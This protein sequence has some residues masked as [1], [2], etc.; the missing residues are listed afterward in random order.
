[1]ENFTNFVS[2]LCSNQ[3]KFI[4]KVNN[5]VEVKDHLIPL[6][7]EPK[8]RIVERLCRLYKLDEK[9]LDILDNNR[10]YNLY[11]SILS[12]LCP[13]YNSFFTFDQKYE[14]IDELIR[15]MI[16]KLYTD[17]KIKKIIDDVKLKP[18]KLI[19]EIKDKSYQSPN[20]IRYIAFLLDL[21][22]IVLPFDKSVIEVYISD[23]TYDVCKPNIILGYDEQKIYHPI[24][25]QRKCMLTYYDH[26]IISTLINQ[27]HKNINSFI[28]K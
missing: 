9:D 12:Q 23:L 22:I 14:L 6:L 28:H 17:I 25:Y 3:S 10:E 15:L 21:N 8:Q 4:P 1:M 5:G 27:E 26:A 24:I 19:E 2:L 20:V 11:T 18:T 7:Q 16:S 13:K